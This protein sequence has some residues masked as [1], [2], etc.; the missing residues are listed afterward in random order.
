MLPAIVLV[1][2]A[3][4]GQTPPQD[5]CADPDGQ[6]GIAMCYGARRDQVEAEQNLILTRI[7][8][9]LETATTEYGAKP[10]DAR[11]ALD[12]AQTHWQAF[13]GEDCAV[14]EAMFGNGNA[15]ALDALDCE[16]A[17]FED[18]NAQLR[19]LESL[20]SHAEPVPQTAGDR[21]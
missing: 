18:R 11:Q 9:A 20:Y 13:A 8:R 7:Y 15:F 16:I 14:R 17:H 5:P 4:I 19:E 1:L 10:A 2:G 3:I 6:L 21:P 12:L